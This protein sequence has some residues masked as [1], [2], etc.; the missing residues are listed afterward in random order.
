MKNKKEIFFILCILTLLFLTANLHADEDAYN[1][2]KAAAGPSGGSVPGVGNPVAVGGSRERTSEPRENNGNR[3]SGGNTAANASP[4]TTNP[5]GNSIPTVQP[6]TATENAREALGS[7]FNRKLET[8]RLNETA[9][10]KSRDRVSS[11]IRDSKLTDETGRLGSSTTANLKTFGLAINVKNEIALAK[12]EITERR[13]G[14]DKWS[15]ALAASLTT[16]APP[17]PYKKF[18]ELQPGDVL[19]IGLDETNF[20]MSETW[21]GI[22]DGN[23][24]KTLGA[25]GSVAA[26]HAINSGD[27]HLSGEQESSTSH[28][29]IFLKEVKGIKLFLEN[30]PGEGP[31]IIPESEFL[32]RYASRGAEVAKLASPLEP[33]DA[34]NLYTAAKKMTAENQASRGEKKGNWFDTTNFGPGKENVVCSESDWKLLQA[35]GRNIPKTNDRFKVKVGVDFSPADFYNNRQFFIVTPLSLSE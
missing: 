24:K 10:D 32:K 15:A 16:K 26:S 5:G 20:T 21:N 14:P 31:C 19:L 12:T 8:N 7:T 18:N 13:K 22:K 1:Q 2:L 17:P 3:N 33:D 25:V 23:W 9:F 27:R 35:A 28:T 29:V 34:A 11:A 6:T 4:Q 30:I